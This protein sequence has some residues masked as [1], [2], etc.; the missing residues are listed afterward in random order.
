M[1]RNNSSCNMEDFKVEYMSMRQQP[2]ITRNQKTS[3]NQH[4]AIDMCLQN[5]LLTLYRP[6]LYKLKIQV[7]A[8]FT[9]CDQS[10]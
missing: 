10:S 2:I 9:V 5:F 1:D 3:L 4:S 7:L 8:F 6:S